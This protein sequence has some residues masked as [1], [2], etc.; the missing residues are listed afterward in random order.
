VLR[1]KAWLDSWWLFRRR[2]AAHSTEFR[3]SP[4]W[5]LPA[6]GQPLD[7]LAATRTVDKVSATT[8]ACALVKK[9]VILKFSGVNPELVAFLVAPQPQTPKWLPLSWSLTQL[10]HCHCCGSSYLHT[11]TRR[12]ELHSVLS[13]PGAPMGISTASEL[14]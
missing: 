3:C 14:A 12:Y 8:I 2:R 13:P 4:A 5:S 9:I 10:A 1:L 11:R 6:A 7:A